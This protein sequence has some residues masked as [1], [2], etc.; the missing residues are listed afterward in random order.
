MSVLRPFLQSKA[1][2]T[3]FCMG[4]TDEQTDSHSWAMQMM[5]LKSWCS[6]T[7]RACISGST[8]AAAMIGLSWCHPIGQALCRAT[9]APSG[10]LWPVSGSALCVRM[11]WLARAAS[12]MLLLLLLETLS[13]DAACSWLQLL[14]CWKCMRLHQAHLC[15]MVTERAQWSAPQKTTSKLWRSNSL[16]CPPAF[17]ASSQLLLR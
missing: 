15:Y 9:S 5:Q 4:R 6:G 16:T 2:C 7:A 13:E 11:R 17:V 14:S 1:C 12:H 10:Q 3:I 8:L